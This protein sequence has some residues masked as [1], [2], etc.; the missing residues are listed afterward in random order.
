MNNKPMNGIHVEDN[1]SLKPTNYLLSMQVFPENAGTAM[2][3]LSITDHATADP[4]LGLSG[5]FPPADRDAQ[6][7]LFINETQI[8]KTNLY[9]AN[10]FE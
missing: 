4:R 7:G 2:A 3:R 1:D 9:E 6:V 10:L 8:D 5:L